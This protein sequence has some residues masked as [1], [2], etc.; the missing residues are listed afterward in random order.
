MDLSLIIPAFI[1][2][3]LIFLAP[4]TLPLVPGYLGFISGVSVSE[5]EDPATRKKARLKIFL[6]GLFYVI[7]FSV[8][9]I[10]L[11]SVFS[12]GGIALAQYRL[13]L[14]RIG[15]VFVIIFGLYM[16]GIFKLGFLSFLNSE[17][18][19]N[20]L[21]KLKP[22]KPSS[23]LILG[24]TFAFG[25][26]PCVGPILAT[27]L[28]LA[29]TTSTVGQGIF[30]LV[31]FSAGLAVPFL[32]LALLYSQAAR[33]ISKMSKLLS[34]ISIIG[35]IFLIFLGILMISDKLL[36]WTSFFYKIFGFVSYE[37]LLDYL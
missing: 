31:V 3:L 24:A 21:T 6:N 8:V 16:I 11:G 4:C 20:I 33:I 17:R 15:G 28:L 2:G 22:G 9:F 5:L 27:I 1:A 36:V 26:S 34:V 19:F 18:K 10:F 12:V 29:T 7:G 25:W 35:G 37:R 14:A 23:S 30:L 32:I 13:W